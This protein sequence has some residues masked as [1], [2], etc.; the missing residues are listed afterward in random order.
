MGNNW[1]AWMHLC[2]RLMVVNL[3]DDPDKFIWKLTAREV[4]LVKSMYGD[5]MSGH[6]RFLRKY[7]WNLKLPLKI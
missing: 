3:S 6:T 2:Q 1:T 4:F 5:M 7:L